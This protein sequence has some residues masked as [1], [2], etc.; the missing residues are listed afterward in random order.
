LE[1][2]SV[3]RQPEKKQ[4]N[5][6]YVFFVFSVLKILGKKGKP[7]TPK[8][9]T[10]L[11]TNPPDEQRGVEYDLENCRAKWFFEQV[12]ND[13]DDNLSKKKTRSLHNDPCIP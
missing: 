11:Y 4:W 5:Q 12:R 8:A 13:D 6:I 1:V 3:G 9:V 10:K 2:E 7:L